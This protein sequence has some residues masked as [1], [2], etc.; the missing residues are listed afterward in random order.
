MSINVNDNGT[1]K[2]AKEVYV[3]NGAEWQEPIEI[4]IHD[5]TSWVLLHKKYDLN[6]NG[7][8]INLYTLVGSPTSKITLK[9][10]IN[11]G[12]TISS[13]NT[14]SPALSIGQF[15]AGSQIYLINNGTIVGAGGAGGLGG[16]YGVRGGVAGSNGGIGINA[17][18]AV[19]ITNN[20]TIAGGGGGGGGGGV[21]RY[22]YTSGKSTYTAYA[23]GGGGGGGAGVVAG[24]GGEGSASGSAGTSTAGGAGGTSSYDPGGAGGARGS[25]GA[26]GD[27][28]NFYGAGAGGIGGAAVS[29]NSNITWTS[30]GTIL[31]TLV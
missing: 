17:D 2:V 29:G 21:T 5:G 23:P 13:S 3:H 30:T 9:A 6:T 26:A 20:G 10:T 15:P 1:F 19:N 24:A 31:G 22:N 18:F 27:G 16:V 25:N 8:G 12:V 11:A 28:G 7:A 4:Y 14:A